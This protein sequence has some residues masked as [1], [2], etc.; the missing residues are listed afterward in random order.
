MYAPRLRSAAAVLLGSEGDPGC[1]FFTFNTY[2][3]TFII[4]ILGN[5]LA[6]IEVSFWTHGT[7]T[8]T[9]TGWTDGRGSQNS[10]LD[11]KIVYHVPHFSN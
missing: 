4:D 5:T 1:I 7:G 10:Y 3:A 11:F 9:G 6:E 2:Q 8:G